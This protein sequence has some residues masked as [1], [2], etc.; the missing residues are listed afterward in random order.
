MRHLFT[1][2]DQE[3][4]QCLERPIKGL[5]FFQNPISIEPCLNGA[6][7][8]AASRRENIRGWFAG[9]EAGEQR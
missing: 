7:L 6:A 4:F 8:R 5:E 9:F 1:P 2:R 3:L